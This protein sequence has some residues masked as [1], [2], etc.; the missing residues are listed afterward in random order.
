MGSL[1]LCDGGA[2]LMIDGEKQ[3]VATAAPALQGEYLRL[4]VNIAALVRKAA[5]EMDLSPMVHVA[6]AFLLGKRVSTE[7][8]VE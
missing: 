7:P 5:I 8:F 3:S 2:T 4:D 1:V 6:Y